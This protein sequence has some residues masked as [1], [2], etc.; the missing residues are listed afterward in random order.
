MTYSPQ[1]L[2]ERRSQTFSLG[3]LPN[4]T[5]GIFCLLL[6]A[7][8][9]QSYGQIS[10]IQ[11]SVDYLNRGN[12]EEAESEARLAMNDPATKALAWAML[13]TIRLQQAKPGESVDCLTKAIELNPKLVGARVTLG[14]AYLL[15][16]KTALA[17]KSFVEALDLDAG[18]FNARFELAKLEASLSHFQESLG[19]AQPIASQLSEANE[20]ILVLAADYAG[21]NEIAKVKDL[22]ATW[23]SMPVPPD[24]A[25]IE[26][27]KVLVAHGLNEDAIHI[28]EYANKG[29]R[30]KPPYELS[31]ILGDASV[32]LGE[33]EKGSKFFEDAF[34]SNPHC[35][36]CA[37]AVSNVAERQGNSEKALAYLIK[38]KLLAPDDPEILFQFGKVCLQR[39]LVLD[40]IPALEKAVQIKPDHDPY[41]YVLGSAN[42]T[43]GNLPEAARLFGQ[44]L[45]K[46]PEDPI[47]NYALGTVYYLQAKYSD[48]EESLKKSIGLQPDQV[49]AYYYLGLTYNT[50]GQQEKASDIFREILKG[51]PNHGPSYTALGTI[52]LREHK[53]DEAQSILNRAVELDPDS[54]QAHFQLAQLLHRLGKTA[55]SDEQ[56]AVARKIEAER[57]AQ[58]AVKL[59][60]LTP[61]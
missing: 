29:R 31:M 61:N 54:G 60:L 36:P 11:A 10:H 47:V 51:H 12:F 28:I 30:G 37:I 5:W 49:A 3:I 18:N 8:P 57:S 40:A 7:F 48:A 2:D 14:D 42:V 13:G 43:K 15:Q 23:L 52:L 41:V 1:D 22:T 19:Y 25:S 34:D 39:N 45:K 4:F 33:L 21:L 56:Y 26:F 27:A 53:Y 20:G 32:K 24:S 46:H 50:L 59:R 35:V 55:E 44:L 17:Q 9:N 58:G 38:A 6:L 16:G